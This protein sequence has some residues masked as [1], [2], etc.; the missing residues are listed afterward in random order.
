VDTFSAAHL[1]TAM[2]RVRVPALGKHGKVDIS[3]LEFI[4]HRALLALDQYLARRWAML[5]LQSAPSVVQRLMDLI[6]LRAVRLEVT[7]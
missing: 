3:A 7:P 4:D 5:V 2:E 1:M 6:P